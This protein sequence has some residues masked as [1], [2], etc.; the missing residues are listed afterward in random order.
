VFNVID[1]YH[2]LLHLLDITI[3]IDNKQ[4]SVPSY[5]MLCTRH[6]MLVVCRR[7]FAATVNDVAIGVNAL[8]FAGTFF[9]KNTAQLAALKQVGPLA[10]L[11]Q[12]ALPSA[13]VHASSSVHA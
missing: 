6:W 13:P 5:N 9:V 8:G 10:I 12:C 1:V 2:R 7:A 11:T 4:T 3:D